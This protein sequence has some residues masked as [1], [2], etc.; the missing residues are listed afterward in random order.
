MKVAQ[1]FPQRL[2]PSGGETLRRISLSK[3]LY[4]D[5][6][7]SKSDHHNMKPLPAVTTHSLVIVV[8]SLLLGCGR[9]NGPQPTLKGKTSNKQKGSQEHNENRAP[10]DI[11]ATAK[12]RV[13]EL[14]KDP[15]KVNEWRET[16]LAPFRKQF[17][18]ESL[19]A[20]LDSMITG[21]G[22]ISDAIR[23]QNDIKQLPKMLQQACK[24]IMHI[25]CAATCI[26]AV[27]YSIA[28]DALEQAEQKNN[29]EGCNQKQHANNNYTAAFAPSAG[30][31]Q[32]YPQLDVYLHMMLR[33]LGTG[34]NSDAMLE[35]FKKKHPANFL[36]AEEASRILWQEIR[37]EALQPLSNTIISKMSN[38]EK[39]S[40]EYNQQKLM[41]NLK[42][43]L[44]LLGELLRVAY[45]KS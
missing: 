3:L 29:K 21:V 37:G 22:H 38:T 26:Q 45:E 43:V 35:E 32:Y 12:Q 33:R 27:P 13:D 1:G 28:Y 7:V 24:G 17:A 8:V 19:K 25:N 16:V 10:A 40:N 18:G 30:G 42:R 39:F 9:N 6:R 41:I 36:I 34:E 15:S 5:F 4:L 11:L 23:V 44:V 31:F 2:L 14:L 20:H